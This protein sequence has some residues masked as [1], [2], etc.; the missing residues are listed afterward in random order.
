M[1]HIADE[2]R[3]NPEAAKGNQVLKKKIIKNQK[4]HS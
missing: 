1:Q 4:S 2:K 3:K